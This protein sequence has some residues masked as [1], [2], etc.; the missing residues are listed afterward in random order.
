[1]IRDGNHV[2]SSQPEGFPFPSCREGTGVVAFNAI[3][4]MVLTV[5][6][7]P[8]HSY[9][10]AHQYGVFR[11]GTIMDL[12]LVGGWLR[13]SEMVSTG[14]LQVRTLPILLTLSSESSSL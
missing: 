12:W 5:Q 11:H 8:S 10:N 4:M 14:S 7:F 3:A 13:R 2:T 6:A 9:C 1:M